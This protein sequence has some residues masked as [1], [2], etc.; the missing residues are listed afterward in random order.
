M[1]T[2]DRWRL[3]VLLLASA[4][5]ALAEE[6]TLTTYDPSPRGVYDQLRMT[7]ETYRS[8]MS[9]SAVSSA[10]FTISRKVPRAISLWLGTVRGDLAG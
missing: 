2:R 1:R 10:C 4:T 3:L 9:S 8:R 5:D 7:G 6:F